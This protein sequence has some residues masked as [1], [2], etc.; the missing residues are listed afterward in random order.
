[1]EVCYVDETSDQKAVAKQ[2]IYVD[3]GS[4]EAESN[5]RHTAALMETDRLLSSAM[6]QVDSKWNRCEGQS[7]RAAH[8][9]LSTKNCVILD[10]SGIDSLGLIGCRE[11][12]TH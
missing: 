1:M 12:N 3:C 10:K 6:A 5:V 9:T 2:E 4:E 11:T 7:L 8:S